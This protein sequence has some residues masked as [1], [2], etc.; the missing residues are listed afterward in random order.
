MANPFYVGDW[1]VEAEQNRI[2]RGGERVRLDPKWIELLTYLAEHPDQVLPKEAILAS[3]WDG[4][5]VS[6]EVLTTAVYELRKALGDDAREP[7]YIKTISRKGYRLIAAVE[8][9]TVDGDHHSQ[10]NPYRGASP[11]LERDA[12]FFFGR[13]EE[14]EDIWKKI[15]RRRLLAIAGPPGAGKT[16]LLRAGVIPASPPRWG[17]LFME[18]GHPPL[19]TLARAL[20]VESGGI[21]DL[22]PETVVDAFSRWRP[23]HSEAVVVLDQFERLFVEGGEETRHRFVELISRV[24]RESD[25][26]VLLSVQDRFLT[27]CYRY[28]GL[29]PVFEELTPLT[30]LD[31][32][33]LKR[34]LVEPARKCGYR[35]EDESLIEE[36]LAEGIR[37][38]SGRVSAIAAELWN[39]RD[40]KGRFLTRQAYRAAVCRVP[41]APGPEDRSAKEPLPPTAARQRRPFAR[42][43]LVAASLALAFA[44]GREV[45]VVMESGHTSASPVHHRLTFRRGLV[46]RARFAPNGESVFYSATWQGEGNRLYST[47]LGSPESR[48]L[49]YDDADILAVSTSGELAVAL[50]V[51]HRRGLTLGTLAVMPVDGAAP[52]PLLENVRAAD[53]PREGGDLAVLHVLDGRDRVEYPIGNVI[54]EAPDPLIG[55]IRLSPRGDLVAFRELD[56]IRVVD[57]AGRSRVLT[58]GWR[59]EA[60]L[61]WSPDGDEIWFSAT[62]AGYNPTT[63]AVTLDGK[64]RILAWGLGIQD[65]APNGDALFR[66]KALHN[67]ITFVDTEQGVERDLSWLDWA[68]TADISDDGRSILFTEAGEGGGLDLAAYFR[69]TGGG[70]AVPLGNGRA[71]A[72][73]PDGLHALVVRFEGTRV[74]FR[75]VPTGAGQERALMESEV[76]PETR[77]R[78]EY[79][80]RWLPDG[81]RLVLF[82]SQ[83]GEGPRSYLV[84]L[85]DPAPRLITRQQVVGKLVTPDG[86]WLLAQG[87]DG[88]GWLYAL[89]GDQSRSVRGLEAEDTPV[90]WSGDGRHLF[91]RRDWGDDP[92]VVSIHRVELAT[93]ARTLVREYV[94]DPIRVAD[95]LPLAMT[96]DARF[97]AYTYGSGQSELFLVQGI[98]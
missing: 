28:R 84:S 97:L 66:R 26:H 1:L 77:A 80:G 40:Q 2:A 83:P 96:P 50:N 61:A 71:A 27:Q 33:G 8:K 36:I 47:R 9:T 55:D 52:R 62:E 23:S 85:D 18:L 29:R 54:Y 53:W 68:H 56:S 41:A 14:V 4:L 21:D 6:D 19:R 30:P 11:Y 76:V 31:S 7:R 75:S 64:T 78:G 87:R 81:R 89:S 86:G 91:V 69:A 94:P 17:I 63:G 93:G 37:G 32:A 72:L 35:F 90:E 79:G 38:G 25:L 82:S 57:R 60:E 46:W 58:Q 16:S 22:E 70:P 88:S 5:V 59:G 15:P 44:A 98:Q 45:A 20:G 67:G 92:N 48:P 12:P 74:E 49:G 73:S 13:E 42:W 95:M 39:Q 10:L 3:V 34:A 43:V 24:A 51:S 65:V